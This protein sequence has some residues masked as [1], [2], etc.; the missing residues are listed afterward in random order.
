MRHLLLVT[1][2]AA[3][4][5]SNPGSSGDPGRRADGAIGDVDPGEPGPGEP[6]PGDAVAGDPV[7]GDPVAGDAMAG[8]P[9]LDPWAGCPTA[10]DYTGGTW[11]FALEVSA[12]ARYCNQGDESQTL[13]AEL[14]RKTMVRIAPG[15]YPIPDGDVDPAVPFRLPVCVRV[16]RGEPPVLDGVG[17][18]T[19]WF[20]PSGPDQ[21]YTIQ[22]R[23]PMR[24]G[25][26]PWDLRITIAGMR[27]AGQSV[28]V[29]DGAMAADEFGFGPLQM[30]LCRG[31][32]CWTSAEEYRNISACDYSA[33]PREQ[34]H[35]EFTDGTR[36]GVLDLDI[37]IGFS[38]ASTEPAL[39]VL[40]EGDI[41]GASFHQDDFWRLFYRPT[42]H[43]FERDFGL[44][45]DAPLGSA[46][47]IAVYQL[48]GLEPRLYTTDC[49]LADLGT[50]WTITDSTWTRP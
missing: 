41:D 11:S 14:G 18:V 16:A 3:C 19:A 40:G 30:V 12:E 48:L 2:I 49:R 20:N 38:P 28:L 9:G 24:A 25:T 22:A 17:E 8:D 10:A 33:L 37:H 50:A 26:Q 1:V 4:T 36:S 5:T 13:A 34:H 46:C 15:I 44:I 29:A 27:T 21:T 6:G 47:G 31:T 35:V 7:A 23:Q 43:H 39:F 32:D 42:H 45:F